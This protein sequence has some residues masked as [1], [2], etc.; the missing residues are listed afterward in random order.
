MKYLTALL[1]FVNHT[2]RVSAEHIS[3]SAD[4]VGTPLKVELEQARKAFFAEVR[5][6]F[7]KYGNDAENIFYE[8]QGG[9][10]WDKMYLAYSKVCDQLRENDA[11]TEPE[12]AEWGQVE[13]GFL[14]ADIG[15]IISALKEPQEAVG[16][17][18]VGQ[19]HDGGSR[20]F[21]CR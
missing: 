15:K 19:A 3:W 13:R 10:G 16:K 2:Y 12:G 4:A 17:A 20:P 1:G 14:L 18:T 9:D 7:L 8:V 5:G 11:L 21:W 6:A